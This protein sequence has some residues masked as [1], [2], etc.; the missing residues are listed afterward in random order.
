[1]WR[2]RWMNASSSEKA[3][4]SQGS[5]TSCAWRRQAITLATQLA[6][7]GI[8]RMS[9]KTHQVVGWSLGLRG[10]HLR[11]CV[12]CIPTMASCSSTRVSRVETVPRSRC[13][14]KLGERRELVRVWV[15]VTNPIPN[16]NPN[17]KP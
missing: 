6:M 1:M 16:P 3:T 2:C 9:L 11:G 7:C 17:P 12:R 5:A 14:L 13:G 8:I 15:R 10:P 4:M